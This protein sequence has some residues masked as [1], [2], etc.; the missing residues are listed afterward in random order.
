M[1]LS[2]TA[3]YDN[4]EDSYQ[5]KC[6]IVVHQ[7][8]TRS[9]KTYNILIWLIVK[10]YGEWEHEI[11][12][13]GRKTFPSLRISVMTDFFAILKENGLYFEEYHNKTDNTYTLGKN[14]VRFFSVDQEQKVRGSRRSYLFLNE[15]NEFSHEDFKQLN[16]RTTKM[17]ILDY[18][19][20]DEFH[21]IYEHILIRDDV[22][23]FKSTFRDNPFLDKRIRQEI[24]NYK[25]T[26]P[27]YWRIYGLGEK[28]LSE[29]TIFTTWKYAAKY[30]GEGQE[31]YGMDFGFNDPTTLV[32]AKYHPDGIVFDELLSET[33]LTSS[34]IVDRLNQLVAE[35]K[36]TKTST[37]Y[38]DCARPEIIED[39]SRAGFNIHSCIKEAGSILR[40][41]NFL[42]RHL[43][44]ITKSSTN[45]I[46]EIQSYKWKVDR[47]G[48]VLDEPVDL[49][50]HLLDAGRYALN[51]IIRRKEYPTPMIGKARIYN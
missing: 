15:A 48:K 7:G 16:Q 40:D 28:G 50:N 35:K 37:I 4:M 2:T 13:I 19:P 23:F 11:I 1:T 12:D 10:C 34:G 39:I 49:N 17:T 9:G 29:S 26:D 43:I 5:E 22:K 44:Y 41:I 20:S 3:I 25:V 14:L 18:N 33:Q 27:N 31:I 36:M 45:M 42:K 46:K 51:R 24:L 8:G 47:N 6:P 32:R 21:W 38:A 30:E